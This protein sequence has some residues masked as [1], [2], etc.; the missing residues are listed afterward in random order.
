MNLFGRI[1]EKIVDF[2]GSV[3]WSL[4]NGISLD[5]QAKIRELL[6]KDYYIILTRNNNHLSTYFINL[7]DFLIGNKWSYWG[8]A[9]LN[10]EG[11]VAP[12]GNFELVESTA[13]G[14]HVDTFEN[15]FNVNSVVLLK[16]KHMPIER[17]TKVFE[18]AITEIGKPYDELFNMNQEEEFSCVE[19]VR[20]AL[21]ADPDY[22]TNFANFEALVKH[23]N[24]ITPHMFYQCADFEVVY[25]IRH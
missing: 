11:D 25:E 18:K 15:V 10:M 14:V 19:L 12:D 17:W 1:A 2:I 16:P 24:R 7:G 8:H 20:A 21:K 6:A 3:K 22:E 5:E 9:L 4:R 23:Y 13:A